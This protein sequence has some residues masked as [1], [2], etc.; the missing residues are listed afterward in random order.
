MTTIKLLADLSHVARPGF[1]HGR[2][3]QWVEEFLRGAVR[4]LPLLVIL[5]GS[6]NTPSSG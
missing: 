3:G 6:V 1:H 4:A 2:S 5:A